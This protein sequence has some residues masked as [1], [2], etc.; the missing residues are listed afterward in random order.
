MSENVLSFFLVVGVVLFLEGLI[1]NLS[2]SM[3]RSLATSVFAAVA[4]DKLKRSPCPGLKE[5][6]QLVSIS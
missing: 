4:V 5:L 1:C 3:G 2:Y 6:N